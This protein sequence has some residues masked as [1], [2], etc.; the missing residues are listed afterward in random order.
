[1]LSKRQALSVKHYHKNKLDSGHGAQL[2]RK[3]VYSFLF[4]YNQIQRNKVEAHLRSTARLHLA[5]TSSTF[6]E[7]M[8][9]LDVLQKQVGEF[10]ESNVALSEKLEATNS[11]VTA[12][13]DAL[14]SM[15]D[16]QGSELASFDSALRAQID[17]DKRE[18]KAVNVALIFKLDSQAK[19]VARLTNASPFVWKIT[20]FSDVLKVAK[21]GRTKSI[22]TEFY[23]RKQG[24]KLSLRVDPDGDQTKRNSYLSVYVG[25]MKGDYDSIL[26]W[27]FCEQVTFS[28]IDQQPDAAQRKN[29]VAVVRPSETPGFSC[30]PSVE[31]N[32]KPFGF[33][34]L[35]SHKVLKTRR[36]VEH[37][38]LFLHAEVGRHSSESR[39][40]NSDSV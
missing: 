37:D 14:G 31:Q 8:E 17:A 32:P 16:A 29:V 30:R 39:D 12:K 18:W 11:F 1:M 13:V 33:R 6:K 24:Y 27:P 2:K 38:T 5:L 35:I 40:S 36:Y 19:E 20:G 26:P 25:I 34:R 9:K 7:T 4:V 23:T 15:V 21:N 22:F 3:I 10:K 28:V